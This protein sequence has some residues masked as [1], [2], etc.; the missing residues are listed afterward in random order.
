MK[1]KIDR[2]MRL[3]IKEKRELYS[4]AIQEIDDRG[5]QVGEDQIPWGWTLYFT[6]TEVVLGDSLTLKEEGKIEGRIK[7]QAEIK[8]G[9]R[10]RVKLRPGDP[11]DARDW[12]RRTKYRMFGADR[13]IE[14]F[15]LNILPMDSEEKAEHAD[16]WAMVGYTVDD[17]YPR[18]DED[19]LVT[20][21]LYVKPSTFERY[22]GRIAD[23]TAD[24][25]VFSAGMVDGFYAEWSPGIDTREVKVLAPGSEQAVETPGGQEYALP[26]IGTVGDVS[27][28]INAKRAQAR[29]PGDPEKEDDEEPE[30]TPLVRP[31]AAIQG[32]VDPA[33][34]KALK[35][36]TGASRWIIGLLAVLIIAVLLKR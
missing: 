32:V 18:Q 1:Y 17:D 21:N 27:L 35:G 12:F 2:G 4:W 8:H 16:A 10:I 11:R 29:N 5:Q 9:R 26:R 22:A 14:N 36:I 19:D 33:V 20:F 25:I 6:A 7:Q 31:E 15:E 23:G 30:T 34:A 28:Y 24:E 13:E 3:E